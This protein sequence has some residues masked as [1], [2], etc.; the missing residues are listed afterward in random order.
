MM[1]YF[2]VFFVRMDVLDVHF[3]C[4]SLFVLFNSDISRPLQYGQIGHGDVTLAV[5]VIVAGVG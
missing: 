2:I 1:Y 4:L 5:H 3:K